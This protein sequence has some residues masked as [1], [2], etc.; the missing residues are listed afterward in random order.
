MSQCKC[1]CEHKDEPKDE[2]DIRIVILQRGWVMVGV[3]KR[4]SESLNTLD[5]GF[6]IR[7]WGTTKGLGELVNGPLPNTKLDAIPHTEFHPLTEVA[8]MKVNA[9]KW[10][11]AQ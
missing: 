10:K 5:H 4:I 3:Y 2:R 7:I 9:D 6:V 11:L 1:G 8:N